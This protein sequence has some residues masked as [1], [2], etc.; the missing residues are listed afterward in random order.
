[1][2]HSSCTHSRRT[3][4][5]GKPD[6]LGNRSRDS[7]DSPTHIVFRPEAFGRFPCRR[8]KMSPS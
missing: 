1:M 5:L 2:T 7:P 8:H 4:S 6:R 3:R